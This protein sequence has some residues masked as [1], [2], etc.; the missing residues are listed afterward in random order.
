M[1]GERYMGGKRPFH[2]NLMSLH[3]E[4][5]GSCLLNN[6]NF[7]NESSTNVLVD[8][9]IFQEEQYLGLNNSFTFKPE[10]INAVVITHAHVDHIGRL[11]LLVRKGFRGKIYT[12]PETF[13]IMRVALL[14]SS[15]LLRSRAKMLNEPFLY[16]DDDVEQALSLVEVVPFEQS[17]MIDE[18]IKLTFFMNGHL[19][20]ASMPLLQAK[21]HVR[22][23]RHYEDINMLFTGDY[24]SSNMFFDVSPLPKWVR[25]LPIS[26]IQ[27]A[28]YGYMDSSEIN[29][30]FENN[31][32]E[33]VKLGKEILAPVLSL[34]RS[35]EILMLLKKL[36][37]EGKLD[38]NVPIYYD[39][40][41]G[42]NYNKLYSSGALRLIKE[43]RRNLFPQNFANVRGA[44][45][46][47]KLIAD[48]SCKI[49]L[50]TSGMGS[51][52]PAQVY[53]PAFLRKKNALIHFTSY[54]AEGTLG[55]K[56]MDVKHDDVVDI[57]GRSVKILADVKNTSEFS[58]HAK[59]DELISFLNDF[60]NVKAVYI[61]HAELSSKEIYASHVLRKTNVK[62][63]CLLGRDYLFRMDG[64]GLVKSFSTK[65][66]YE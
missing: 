4:V 9:G 18:N 27:E 45:F 30:V 51:H 17:V 55:R 43:D 58:K 40:K 46:R 8:C 34:G 57:A 1:K 25:Q 26:I 36:Q 15:K 42:M 20:G 48:R 50:T 23:D 11:P 31:I 32:L 13:S 24:A 41:L 56:I 21:Y 37:N 7:P 6:F 22:G 39:G 28:T 66:R 49:I 44:E 16:D 19:P 62:D 64:Y 12:S 38:K 29:Y 60:E 53:L 52:G 63:V 59:R 33:A 5:T 54:L 14:D 10:N 65:F 61:N 47:D 35:Q 2:N 3:N